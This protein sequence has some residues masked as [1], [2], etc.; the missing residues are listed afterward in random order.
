M[1]QAGLAYISQLKR[2][3]NKHKNKLPKAENPTFD[4]FYRQRIVNQ[5]YSNDKGETKI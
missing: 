1:C 3:L 5:S 4:Q 2:L